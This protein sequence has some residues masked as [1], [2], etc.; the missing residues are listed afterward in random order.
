[1][2]SRAAGG[3]RSRYTLFEM[4]IVL[5]IMT[6][7]LGLAVPR[8]ARIPAG[9]VVRKT[10]S[11]ISRAYSEAGLRA[12]A[13]GHPARL[14]LDLRRNCFE[15][16]DARPRSALSEMPRVAEDT[17]ADSHDKN[18]S[19]SDIIGVYDI[20][21]AVTWTADTRAKTT[22]DKLSILFFSN[23]EATGPDV[24]LVCRNRAFRISVDRLTGE[25][26]IKKSPRQ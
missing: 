23:G 1:M 5:M 18:S 10:M 17:S 21:P 6:L 2:L 26:V 11:E 4:L 19:Q 14:E 9:P 12:R 25:A 13:T 20:D 8:I 22:D 3:R 16:R 15:L 24:Q 7:V